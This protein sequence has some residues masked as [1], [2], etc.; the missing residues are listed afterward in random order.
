M[1]LYSRQEVGNE[2]RRAHKT[3]WYLR[4]TT[5]EY[6]CTLGCDMNGTKNQQD[7]RQN[8]DHQGY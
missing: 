5:A 3:I 1:D 6:D 8:G 4:G 7:L 2:R